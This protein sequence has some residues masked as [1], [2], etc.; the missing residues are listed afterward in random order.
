MLEDIVVVDVTPLGVFTF[1][2]NNPPIPPKL[3]F[4]FPALLLLLFGDEVSLAGEDEWNSF[5]FPPPE[6]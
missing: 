4:L 1:L 6:E 3:H 2:L 5:R